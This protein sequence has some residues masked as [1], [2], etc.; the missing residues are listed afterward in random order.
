MPRYVVPA[1]F[2]IE[3]DNEFDADD[4]ASRIQGLAN[5][6]RCSEV[7]GFLLLDESIPTMEVLEGE[8]VFSLLKFIPRTHSEHKIVANC[9]VGDDCV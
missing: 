9:N 3:A 4:L 6:G 5:H 8:N 7:D 2:L 1:F